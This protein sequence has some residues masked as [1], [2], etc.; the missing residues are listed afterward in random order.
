MQ[1]ERF[2]SGV[3]AALIQVDELVPLRIR[4]V[5]NQ[6]ARGV[7]VEPG[8]RAPDAFVFDFQHLTQLTRHLGE[9][10]DPVSS[11]THG[12]QAQ[13]ASACVFTGPVVTGFGDPSRR[14]LVPAQF[15]ASAPTT[16]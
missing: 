14:V 13:T 5:V 12:E 11:R 7:G 15:V 6:L 10:S 16:V 2:D 1:F 3:Q 9:E 8:H 4:F